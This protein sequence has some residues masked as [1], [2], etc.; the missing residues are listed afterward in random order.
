MAYLLL[1]QSQSVEALL[2]SFFLR[3]RST[4]LHHDLALFREELDVLRKERGSK[5]LVPG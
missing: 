2:S 4:L 3:F 5:R 1:R